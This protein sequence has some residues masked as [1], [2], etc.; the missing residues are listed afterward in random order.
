MKLKPTWYPL[1]LFV[2]KWEF[3]APL[4]VSFI[5]MVVLTGYEELALRHVPEPVFLHYSVELGV[6]SVGSALSALLL[7]LTVMGIIIVN[8]IL[9]NLLLLNQRSVALV[10]AWSTVPLAALAFGL[11]ELVLRI[12]GA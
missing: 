10:L 8:G 11:I 2:R 7:P 4:M 6:D 9:A 12:N 3:V 5:A 1:Q